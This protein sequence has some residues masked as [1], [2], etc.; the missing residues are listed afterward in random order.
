MAGMSHQTVRLARGRH[1]TP[2]DGACAMELASMLAGERFSDRP[3]CVDPVIGAFLRAFNDR[4]G[5]RRRQQLRPYAAAVVGTR[6]DAAATRARRERCLRYAAGTT[7]LSLAARARLA[8]LVGLLP[9]LRPDVGAGEW[10]AREAIARGDEA[11]GF[12]LLEALIAETKAS[13]AATLALTVARGAQ[14][15]VPAPAAE[16]VVEPDSAQGE[17]HREAGDHRAGS[18]RLGR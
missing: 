5:H 6:T 3:Q 8:L 11:G 7:T 13:E 17:Q 18:G 1:G 16:L 9:A 2:A 15:G 10:A 12:A 4:L 14:A